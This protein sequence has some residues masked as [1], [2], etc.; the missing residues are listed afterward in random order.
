MLDEILPQFWPIGLVDAGVE[1]D[2]KW[3]HHFTFVRFLSLR[4][5]DVSC[6]LVLGGV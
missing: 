2:K 3:L 4:P 6:L 5:Q 1:P